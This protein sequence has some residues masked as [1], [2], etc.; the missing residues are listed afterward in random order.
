MSDETCPKCGATMV[1]TRPGPGQGFPHYTDTAGCLT[2]QLAAERE[3]NE[4]LRAIETALGAI[5]GWY[6]QEMERSQW[7]DDDISEELRELERDLEAAEAS[8]EPGQ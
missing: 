5:V 8:Q 3:K 4:R 2:R 1:L 7:E 6:E